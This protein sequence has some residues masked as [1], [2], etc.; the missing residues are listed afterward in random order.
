MGLLS[1]PNCLESSTKYEEQDRGRIDL[2]HFVA[3]APAVAML[4]GTWH[5]GD[6]D[7]LRQPETEGSQGVSVQP[8]GSPGTPICPVDA[9]LCVNSASL[10]PFLSY[11]MHPDAHQGQDLRNSHPFEL[12]ENGE[13][14]I[15]C[16]TGKSSEDVD[17]RA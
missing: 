5:S 7:H 16:P 4:A 8:E 1:L 11:F 17:P 6:P 12:E 15:Y 10:A 14:R 13:L 2:G 3:A 9:V